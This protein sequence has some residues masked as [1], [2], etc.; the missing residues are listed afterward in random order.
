MKGLAL[1]YV[2]TFG[3]AALALFNPFVGVC[4]YWILD[5]VRPQYMFAWA[6]TEGSF[7][8]IVAVATL[9]GWALKGFGTWDLGRGRLIF[10]LLVANGLFVLLSAAAAPYQDVALA[11]LIE[12]LKRTLLFTIAI[13]TADSVLRVKQLAWVMTGSAGYLGLE[14]NLRYLG[15]FNEAQTF[16]YGGMDNNSLAISLLTC[17]GVALFLGFHSRV[18]WQKAIA[19]G[20]TALISHTILLTFSRG[21]MLGLIVAGVAAIAIAPKRPKYLLPLAGAALVVLSLTGPEVRA[22]FE[23]S[24][25]EDRD[26]DE[27]AQSRVEL[28]MDCVEVMEK[29]PLLGAGPDHFGLI[30][31]EF[32]WPRGKEA[33]SLWFQS[34]AEI[35]LPGVLSLLMFYLVAIWRLARLVRT[36]TASEEDRW[37]RHAACMVVTSL[38]AFVVS[39]QFVTMEGLETPL[40]V[41]AIAVATLRLVPSRRAQEVTAAAGPILQPAG[42]FRRPL[43]DGQFGTKSARGQVNVPAPIGIRRF[44]LAAGT[45]I[46][47]TDSRARIELRRSRPNTPSR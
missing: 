31:P 22:R 45:S 19:F 30:A 36:S 25:A 38:A 16:G 47:G 24:F 18:W 20:C 12:Q 1:T 42:A 26:R 35:G 4:V 41:V 7:S 43:H 17:F 10:A 9:I 13:T 32:G 44:Q 46:P 21:G 11:F 29:Y 33:H 40:Y 23:S 5:I 28:W 6:G 2:L 27:S 8:E 14:L 39:V 34:G 15:G 37:T 3:G